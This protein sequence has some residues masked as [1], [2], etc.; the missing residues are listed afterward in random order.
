MA[1]G[2]KPPATMLT[3]LLRWPSIPAHVA[4]GHREKVC[5]ESPAPLRKKTSSLQHNPQGLNNSAPFY[6]SALE[7]RQCLAD[8]ASQA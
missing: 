1:L 5:A 6:L 3:W 7:M 4:H 8:E 2:A